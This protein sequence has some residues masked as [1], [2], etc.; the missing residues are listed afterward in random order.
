MSEQP[1]DA[2]RAPEE[3]AEERGE[4][5]AG[6]ADSACLTAERVNQIIDAIDD[7]LRLRRILGAI[8]RELNGLRV[9][10][11]ESIETDLSE[12]LRR[13]RSSVKQPGPAAEQRYRALER[14]IVERLSPVDAA[15]AQ[16]VSL[17]T[18]YR[19]RMAGA[20]ELAVVLDDMWRERGRSQPPVPVNRVT[21]VVP[22]PRLFLGRER[23]MEQASRLLDETRLVVVAGPAGIGKTALGAALARHRATTQP[24]FWHRFRAGL[25][26]SVPGVLFA[27]ASRLSELGATSL[28]TF[29]QE[30][31][32][33]SAWEMLAQSLAAHSIDERRMALCFDDG[34]LVADNQPVTSLI[35]A[36]HSDAPR[37]AI[38]VMARERLPFLREAAYMELTGLDIEMVRTYLVA[39]GVRPP[40]DETVAV[41]AQLTGGNPQVLHLAVGAMLHSDLDPNRLAGRLLD[42]SDVRAFFFDQI[43]ATL[44]ESQ[45]LLLSAAS[46]VR[47]PATA[48]FLAGALESISPS[49]PASL[50]EL[51]RR[52]L[53]SANLEGLRLHSTVR[54]FARRMLTPTRETQLHRHFAAAYEREGI[55]E[56]ACHHWIQAGDLAAART[57][58]LSVR[59][60]TDPR[61]LARILDLVRRLQTLG[62]GD[63][64]DVASFAATL[65]GARRRPAR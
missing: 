51:G 30:S 52:F 56:E 19:R 34:D 46:L 41:L 33:G 43:Y 44:T 20:A 10:G 23:E 17:R 32:S 6:Q 25:S 15:K 18:L 65:A 37:A 62:M 8:G 42:V 40:P 59:N 24:V 61:R 5:Q 50:A 29:L 36:L 16:F 12:A 54:E 1:P 2:E 45:Q 27:L 49:V 31:A 47:E 28:T 53:L 21:E 63:D 38:V 64:P 39:S 7:P 26:D 13:A 57:A 4:Q 14:L 60:P 3:A 35:A 58:L 55:Y 48:T 22:Q 9:P 11:P